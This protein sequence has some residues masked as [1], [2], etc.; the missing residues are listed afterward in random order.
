MNLFRE[1]LEKGVDEMLG[2]KKTTKEDDLAALR[3]H[4]NSDKAFLGFVKKS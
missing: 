3:E 4:Q 1:H 2:T